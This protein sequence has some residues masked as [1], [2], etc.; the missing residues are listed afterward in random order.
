MSTSTT[1]FS[2]KKTVSFSRPVV[3]ELTMEIITVP[4][5][6][7]TYSQ[8]ISFDG[9]TGEQYFQRQVENGVWT[10]KGKTCEFRQKREVRGYFLS[11]GIPE[12]VLV[13]VR[14]IEFTIYE[15]TKTRERYYRDPKVLRYWTAEEWRMEPCP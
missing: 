14:E 4:G 2:E 3:G 5:E 7:E 11:G 6:G 8:N 1:T 9:M 10:F 13:N 15:K 12:T